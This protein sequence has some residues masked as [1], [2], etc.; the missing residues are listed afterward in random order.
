MIEMPIIVLLVRCRDLFISRP[1]QSEDDCFKVSLDPY[2]GGSE[3][4]EIPTI[5]WKGSKWPQ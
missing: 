5:P 1:A 3:Q 2:V 4:P